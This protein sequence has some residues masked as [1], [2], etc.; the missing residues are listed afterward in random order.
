MKLLIDIGNTTTSIGLWDSNKLSKVSNFNNKDFL[1]KVKKYIKTSITNIIFTSV[2]S[3]KDNK[4]IYSHLRQIFKCEV[5][6][7]KSSSSFLG[8]TNGYKQPSKLG[9]DRWVTIVASYI[10]YKSPLVIVDCGTA[11]SIDI[12]N[13]EGIH[14]GGY[15]L[16]GIDGYKRCFENAYNL[17]N[18][19]LIETTKL[20]KKSLPVKTDDGITQ[21][22]LRMII[23]LIESI[24][25]ELNKNKKQSPRLLI[26]GGY[27]KIISDNLSIKNNYES[28]LVLRCLGVIS[29]RI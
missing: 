16:A 18:T 11:V 7:L 21:G 14:Y 26:S 28:D 19:K 25:N 8:V 22:Y 5:R 3:A 24:Y 1:N 27:G 2:I 12:V 4:L 9:D 23:S 13:N 15:I 6:Q 20:K 10:T 29:K 17:K